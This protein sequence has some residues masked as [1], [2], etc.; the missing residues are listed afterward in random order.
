MNINKLNNRQIKII[1]FA[2]KN[3]SFQIKN[4]LSSVKEEFDVERLTIIRDLSLLTKELILDKKGKGRNTF[5][6]VSSR[7]L[8]M[9]D[10]DVDKYFSVPHNKRDIKP[11]FDK[12]VIDLLKSDI[13]S[14]E[15]IKR[16]DKAKI[17]YDK[18]IKSLKKESPTIFKKEWERLIIEL[19]WKSSE[20]EGNTYTLLE[21]EF[22]IKEFTLAK[23]KDKAEAQMILNHKK[24][25]D[26]ILLKPDYFKK[27]TVD[28]IK[29]IHSLLV[30][31]IDIKIDFR[32]RPVGI[33][34]TLYRPMSKKNE[35][36]K[37]VN[38]LVEKTE[39]IDNHILKAFM[40]LVMIAYIQP[41]EDGNKRTSRIIT[42]A[43]LHANNS[44]M[45]SYR[46]LDAT[47]YKKAILLFYEQ[48]NISYIKKIFIEQLE[49]S[50]N[51]YFK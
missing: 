35:I 23:G 12:E 50:I 42:N 10:Y 49:F 3:K 20:I 4:L 31:D 34:G 38:E 21:T 41:F 25:L 30:K 8:L 1:E 51:N 45:L 15:E 14:K 6:Q 5:Y 2:E 11:F 43:I 29:E 39:K 32:N 19:S 26:L 16:L 22:L 44:P 28:K 17:K 18:T 37:I 40:F 46:D 13:F 27:I 48:N 9:K 33:T 47:E 24:I 36:E 7:Y